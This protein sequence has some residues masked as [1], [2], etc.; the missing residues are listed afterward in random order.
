MLLEE[1]KILRHPIS[2]V[3]GR[4]IKAVLLINALSQKNSSQLDVSLPR[5]QSEPMDRR[6]GTET[7]SARVIAVFGATKP[8]CAYLVANRRVNRM[9]VLV[10][11]GVGIWLAARRFNIL[12]SMSEMKN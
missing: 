1:A 3:G 2:F 8:D 7:A 6:A 5:P 11:D 9:K 4:T 10:D 12:D